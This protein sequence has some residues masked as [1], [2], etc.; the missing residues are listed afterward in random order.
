MTWTSICT[1]ICI[2]FNK[3]WKRKLP[4]NLHRN[5]MTVNDA[6]NIKNTKQLLVSPRFDPNRSAQA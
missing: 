5:R 4:H 2:T 6:S 1:I 3:S